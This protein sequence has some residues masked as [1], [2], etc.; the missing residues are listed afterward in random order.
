MP[1]V[2]PPRRPY[3]ER[4]RAFTSNLARVRLQDLAPCSASSI[5]VPDGSRQ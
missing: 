2:S 5:A 1:E 3:G 4:N